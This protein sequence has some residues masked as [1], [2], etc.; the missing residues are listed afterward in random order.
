MS[1]KTFRGSIKKT[2]AAVSIAMAFTLAVPPVEAHGPPD[3]ALG[4]P[5]ATAA[6]N[7]WNT[8]IYT[9]FVT[10]VNNQFYAINTYLSQIYEYMRVG[11]GDPDNGTG[12]IGT[13]KVIWEETQAFN[14]AN[15]KM[16]AQM[17]R[18]TSV[19]AAVANRVAASMP[20][21]RACS[22]IPRV[23]GARM[24]GG[25]GGGSRAARGGLERIV[26]N[27]GAGTAPSSLNQAGDVFSTHATKYCSTPDIQFTN[28]Q[29]H[30]AF[31]CTAVSTMPDGD[32]RVQSLFVPAHNYEQTAPSIAANLTFS[33]ADEKQAAKDSS[34]NIISAFSP[35]GLTR[36]MEAT[37]EGKQYLTRVKVFNTRISPA[38]H[39]LAQIASYRFPDA[40]IP[41]FLSDGWKA[42]ATPVYGRIFP[43][44][45]VPDLPS[46]AEVVR[47]EVLRRFA[48]F[49]AESWHQKII[50]DN[51]QANLLRELNTT[52]SVN[53]YV[54]WELHNRME[55]NN[56]LQASI[57]SQLV[58][59]TSK[60]ELDSA[61][62][63]V[64]TAK[65]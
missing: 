12:L 62:R 36:E 23:M 15:G 1:Q 9:V 40:N 33:T 44:M 14:E 35:P 45:S 47:F 60:Q 42:I 65:K 11:S 53:L 10:T 7:A 37:P 61:L 57:L 8:N 58:N 20:D 27:S 19:D 63:S 25:G 2:M 26:A 39:A 54:N 16:N 4:D 55:E 64:Y 18:V 17:N 24:A 31:G 22:E 49:G 41:S 38:I 59:P 32:A 3:G 29:A 52:A 46:A 34:K 51:D 28:G 50:Q 30:T 56:A 48:D 5:V 21:S 43:G 6:F 13:M